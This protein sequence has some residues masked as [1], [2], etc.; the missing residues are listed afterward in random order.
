[1]YGSAESVVGDLAEDLGNR[2]SLFLT[3]KVWT[4]GR[5]AGVQ[6]MEQSLRR[7]K[8][9]M[10]DLMQVHNLVDWKTQLATIRA[11]QK[12]GRVRYSGITHYTTSAFDDIARV[13][14][15]EKPDFIQ[16]YYS[17]LLTRRAEE[18]V[19]TPGSGPRYRGDHEQALRDRGTLQPRPR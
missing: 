7:F 16:I 18:R 10:I 12:E 2:A 13:M 15:T 4:T 19:L 8:T 14:R 6:Q 3:T 1:M 17:I 9:G 11:W 5:E